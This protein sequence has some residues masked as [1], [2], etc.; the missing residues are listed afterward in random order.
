[1][2]IVIWLFVIGALATAV[3][4]QQLLGL[5][6]FLVIGGAVG[7]WMWLLFWY[8]SVT[9]AP[10]GVTVANPFRTFVVT[11][12]AIRDVDTKYALTLVTASGRVQAWGAPAAGRYAASNVQGRG[13]A[14]RIPTERRGDSA[15]AR[16]SDLLGVPS[17]LAAYTVRETW[18]ALRDAGWLQSGALEGEGVTV[19][20]NTLLVVLAIALPVA[21]VAIAVLLH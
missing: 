19:R 13:E 17:G 15:V 7:Y 16:P 11:W 12:P 8:P 6:R 2:T 20:L 3:W 1:M 18:T 9:V 10:S 14:R 21:G 5:A 4:E